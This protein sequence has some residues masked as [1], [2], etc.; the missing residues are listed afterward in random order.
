MHASLQGYAHFRRRALAAVAVQHSVPRYSP[1][2]GQHAR[3][4][5]IAF[6]LPFVK[7][8]GLFVW[9]L[10]IGTRSRVA[11]L[12]AAFK[13]RTPAPAVARPTTGASAA[14]AAALAA[15]PVAVAAVDRSGRAAGAAKL[16]LNTPPAPASS[17]AAALQSRDKT[18]THSAR[19]HS[20]IDALPSDAAAALLHRRLHISVDRMRRLAHSTANAPACLAKAGHAHCDDCVTANATRLPHSSKLYAPSHC[21]HLLHKH[22][23][24][25]ALQDDLHSEEEV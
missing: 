5:A 17:A 12:Y 24:I 3:S 2:P 20:H 14:G 16:A 4:D 10:E 15:P 9:D 11:A 7:R 23:D 13:A 8:N 22:M 18:G 21:G 25:V 6:C 1:G 19:A